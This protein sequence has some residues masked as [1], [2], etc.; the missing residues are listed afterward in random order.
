[1]RN[2]RLLLAIS[3][4]GIVAGIALTAAMPEKKF[5]HIWYQTLVLAAIM[6]SIFMS[7][8]DILIIMMLSSCVVWGM[9]FFEIITGLH[10]LILETAI[11]L[12]SGSALGWYELDYKKEKQKQDAIVEYKKNEISALSKKVAGLNKECHAINEELRNVRKIFTP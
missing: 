7:I 11:I 2:N 1:M 6:L 10:Q 12:A 3:V 9:G 8:K 5:F 4:L